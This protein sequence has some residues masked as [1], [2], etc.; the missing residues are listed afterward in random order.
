MAKKKKRVGLRE[1]KRIFHNRSLHSQIMDR[2]KTSKKLVSPGSKNSWKWKQN[3]NRY[4]MRFVDTKMLVKKRVIEGDVFT[5]FGTAKSIKQAKEF[6]RGL[7]ASFMPKLFLPLKE[8]QRRLSKKSPAKVVYRKKNG[9]YQLYVAPKK[10]KKFVF[11]HA[12]I[13]EKKK[14]EWF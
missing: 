3:P 9:K 1:A 6:K 13:I 8:D 2:S 12:I 5:P 14:G 10:G 11:P 4:D 7:T